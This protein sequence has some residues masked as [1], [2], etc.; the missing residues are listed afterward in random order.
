M[1]KV[2]QQ[3]FSVLAAGGS[4][5]MYSDWDGRYILNETV[6][7]VTRNFKRL[8]SMTEVLLPSP[9]K[10]NGGGHWYNQVRFIDGNSFRLEGF[11]EM[12][13]GAFVGKW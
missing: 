3:A 1:P 9:L 5:A 8:L 6:L 4:E 2:G 7:C 10:L 11:Q 13:S 12:L